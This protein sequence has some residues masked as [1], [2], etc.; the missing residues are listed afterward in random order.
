MYYQIPLAYKYLQD[1]KR[2]KMFFFHFGEGIEYWT[3]FLFIINVVII[4]T[5]NQSSALLKQ[6][7]S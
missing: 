3:G 5:F 1:E 2:A 6:L 7:H 4:D